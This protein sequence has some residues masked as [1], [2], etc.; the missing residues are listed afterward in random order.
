MKRVFKKID[1]DTISIASMNRLSQIFEKYIGLVDFG[2]GR[3]DA[4]EQKVAAAAR[5]ETRNMDKTSAKRESVAKRQIWTDPAAPSL[6]HVKLV[7]E[8]TCVFKRAN[9]DRHQSAYE[10]EQ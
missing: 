2:V 8:R 4:L 7:G 9:K 1:S 10:I 5:M 3:N 6:K